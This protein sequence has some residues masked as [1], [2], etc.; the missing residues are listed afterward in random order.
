MP[1]PSRNGR[2][3]VGTGSGGYR[4]WTSNC[5]R[6]GAWAI[7]WMDGIGCCSDW[8][9]CVNVSGRAAGGSVEYPSRHCHAKNYLPQ[10]HH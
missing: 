2:C 8:M 6:G 10:L 1:M 9:R 3:V 7:R 4:Q 5:P